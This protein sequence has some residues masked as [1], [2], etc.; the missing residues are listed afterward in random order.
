V[1]ERR[2]ELRAL[3]IAERERLG[4]PVCDLGQPEPLEP[5]RRRRARA[6]A[7]TGRPFQRTAPPSGSRT[8]RTIRIAVVLPA[9]LGPTKP[10]SWPAPTAKL[11]SSSATVSP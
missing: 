3:L 11:R 9:P 8:P 10:K 6:A 1:H 2:A 4:P 5:P 7:S